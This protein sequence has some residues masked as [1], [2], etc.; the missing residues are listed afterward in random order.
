MLCIDEGSGL[1]T[2]DTSIG[3]AILNADGSLS[4]ALER[5]Q[6]LRN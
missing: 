6:F 5:F 3:E 2:E 1:I 4:T